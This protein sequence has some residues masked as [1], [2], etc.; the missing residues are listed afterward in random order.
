M[1]RRSFAT[2]S[3][4]LGRHLYHIRGGS[5]GSGN[6]NSVATPAATPAGSQVTPSSR[7]KLRGPGGRFITSPAARTPTE[8]TGHVTTARPPLARRTS[9]RPAARRLLTMT[10]SPPS[11]RQGGSPP[12]SPPPAPL[13]PGP[14]HGG[15]RRN[16]PIRPLLASASWQSY[17]NHMQDRASNARQAM[18]SAVARHRD[19]V[20]EEEERMAV[21]GSAVGD[22]SS[23]VSDV[24]AARLSNAYDRVVAT[25][26]IHSE[27]ETRY[28]EVLRSVSGTV[29]RTGARTAAP[30]AGQALGVAAPSGPVIGDG[31]A[32]MHTRS[33]SPGRALVGTD[34]SGAG[35]G[36]RAAAV[37]PVGG[38]AMVTDCEG[39]TGAR[40][41][42]APIV[43]RA[44]VP[45]AAE[46]S[47]VTTWRPAPPGGWVTT[48]S[49]PMV[50][51]GLQREAVG[52]AG[53]APGPVGVLT[54][55][56]TPP[57][58]QNRRVRARVAPSSP[59]SPVFVPG[60]GGVASLALRPDTDAGRGDGGARAGV[61]GV[62]PAASHGDGRRTPPLIGGE[63]MLSRSPSTSPPSSPLP[64]ASRGKRPRLDGRREAVL[65]L[66]GHDGS[67]QTVFKGGL[68]SVRGEV[69]RMRSEVVVVRS[70]AA[71]TLRK[72]DAITS[73][74]D[75]DNTREK[76]VL[77]RLQAVESVLQKVYERLPAIGG[78]A[79]AARTSPRNSS[80]TVDAIYKIRVRYGWALRVKWGGGRVCRFSVGACSIV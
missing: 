5:L 9:A 2:H 27:A 10:H 8:A 75:A 42:S 73:R 28:K 68:A 61:G 79:A 53:S 23:P 16:D 52:R 74:L 48:P 44:S 3:L 66:D 38:E 33:S 26:K 19:L 43:A 76:D 37:L 70:Q 13:L 21:E 4:V 54:R 58:T 7:G 22:R 39:R 20:D 80:N 47:V 11:V 55:P 71:S 15:G 29:S 65:D 41:A 56:L 51:T 49:G 63:P 32:A 18:L 30:I 35:G 34:P 6:T 45:A 64:R 24:R 78:A 36:E 40:L 14:V 72:V 59:G 69:T 77:E 17:V 25:M 46:R 50:A 12:S 60:P 67:I 62:S 57:M 31:G 1:G